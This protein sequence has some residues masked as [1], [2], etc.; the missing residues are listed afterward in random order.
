M[1]TAQDLITACSE[2]MQSF[3][4]K[5]AVIEDSAEKVLVVG[6]VHG[7]L[8]TLQYVLGQL[9]NFDR[10]VFVG[11]YI[12][13]GAQD[14]E[15]LNLLP[16]LARNPNVVLLPGNHDAESLV[17]PRNFRKKIAGLG[18]SPAEVTETMYVAAFKIAPIAYCNSKHKML[19]VHGGIPCERLS[20]NKTDN[21][22]FKNW[23]KVLFDPLVQEILWNDFTFEQA[24][25]HSE[26]SGSRE[27]SDSA[28]REFMQFNGL[29]L[30][31]R[32]HQSPA[33]NTIYDLG[34]GKSIVTVGSASVYSG[35]RAV[36][37][38]PEKKLIRF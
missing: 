36:F 14:I 23:G 31:V 5:P 9:P 8:G 35:N 2:L 29:E 3:S 20:E 28:A 38:L 11:D 26:R 7:D 16:V 19:V 17:I 24:D 30:L 25:Q 10:V 27:V 18:K 15:V 21:Y 4:Q 34:A 1:V 6:D 37:A 13:R 12:D 33:F 22:V 32:G